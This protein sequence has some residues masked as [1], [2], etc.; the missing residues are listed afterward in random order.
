MTQ[1]R[2]PVLARRGIVHAKAAFEILV[3][4]HDG[5]QQV[6]REYAF[7]LIGRLGASIIGFEGQSGRYLVESRDMIL[8]RLAFESRGF[9]EEKLRQ[10]IDRVGVRGTFVDVGANVG[11]TTIPAVCRFGYSRVIA[12]EPSPDNL[13]LLRAVLALNDIADMVQVVSAAASGERG[14][15]QLELSPDNSGDNRIRMTEDD[16]IFAERDRAT[17]DVDV[18][19]LDDLDV[20]PSDVGLLWIDVQGHEGHVLSG[21]S[22]LMAQRVPTVIEY[23]PYALQR[24]NGLELLH[25]IIVNNFRT[26]TDLATGERHPVAA[27]FKLVE[28]YPGQSHTDLLLG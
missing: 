26:F 28:A 1:T 8:G 17:V 14:V 12:V 2:F 25:T 5:R 3:N 13:R 23:W 19:T 24:A 20:D 9:D 6:L 7:R 15:M 11:V 18:V 22:R 21:A 4:T 16:G 27:I 10:V